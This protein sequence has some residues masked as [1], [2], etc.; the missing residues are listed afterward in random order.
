[1]IINPSPVWTD[2]VLISNQ[3]LTQFMGCANL[4]ICTI[5]LIWLICATLLTQGE[6]VLVGLYLQDIDDL[7]CLISCLIHIAT[8]MC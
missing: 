7:Q 1:M 4:L 2:P 8:K 3:T 5:C 6:I